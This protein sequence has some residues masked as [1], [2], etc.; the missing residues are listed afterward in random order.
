MNRLQTPIADALQ[1]IESAAALD[2]WAFIATSAADAPPV[3]GPLSGVPFGVKDIID[4]ARMPTSFGLR[5][6]LRKAR[7]DAWCVALVRAAGAVPIGKTRTT[8]HAYR[9]PAPTRN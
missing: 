3:D 9:D 6:E 5:S 1:K 8:A 7:F 4:V 2:A